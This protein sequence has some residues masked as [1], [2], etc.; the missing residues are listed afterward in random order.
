MVFVVVL[1]MH[2]KWVRLGEGGVNMSL[3]GRH[4]SF[5]LWSTVKFSWCKIFNLL[6][7]RPREFHLQNAHEPPARAPS[8][9]LL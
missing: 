5:T 8:S 7:K 4:I 2:V 9:L 6:A 3:Y 1:W